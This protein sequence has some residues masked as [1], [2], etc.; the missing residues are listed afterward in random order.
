M[1]ASIRRLLRAPL[2]CGLMAVAGLPVASAS[3]G[4]QDLSSMVSVTKSERS[5]TDLKTK[6]VT[7]TAT[8]TIKNISTS[9]IGTPLQAVFDVSSAGVQAL[10][11][12]AL[13]PGNPY[14]RY[15][16]D[17]ASNVASGTLQPSNSVTFSVR[18][19]S[20]S[21]LRY[22]Y[23]II[24]YGTVIKA[25]PTITWINPAAINYGTA[26]SATQLNATA[27]VPGS[28]AYTPAA[29]TVLSV[30]GHSLK[31][32]FTPTD[33]TNYTLASATVSITVNQAVNLPPVANAGTDRTVT[34]TYGQTTIKIALDGSSSSDPDGTITA[35]SWSGAPKPD[36]S[37]APTVALGEGV[38][39]FSLVVTDNA[40]ATSAPKNVVIT[41]IREVVRPPLLLVSPPPYQVAAGSSIPLT[42][43][44]SATSPDNRLVSLAATPAF[45]NASYG[46]TSGATANGTLTF[47]PDFPQS[48]AYFITFT[49][50]D[51]YGLTSSTTIPITVAKT[52]RPPVLTLQETATI[53][54]GA[55]LTIPV[56]A[57]DPDGDILTLTATGLPRNAIFS[58][59]AGAINFNPDDNQAGTFT[60][61]VTASDGQ[62]VTSK[63]ITIA[64]IDVPG[65]GANP[66]EALT[67]MVNPVEKLNFL[68]TQRI[69]GT[70]NGAGG[71]TSSAQKAALIVGMSPATG[72]Q[73]ATLSVTLTGDS[74]SY[75]THFAAGTSSTSFG[76][77][78]TVTAL[79][80]VSPTQAIA[81][82]VIDATAPVGARSIS[83]TTGSETAPSVVAFNVM[84]GKATVT[85][86]LLDADSGLAISGSPVIL[87]GTTFS[88]TTGSDGVF[89][90]TG[91]PS[92]VQ[93]VAVNP[94]NHEL[95]IKGITL[96]TG[97][98]IDLGELRTKST[99]YD[100]AAPPTK[101][102]LSVLGRGM[103]DTTGSLKPDDAK[104]VIRDTL[105]M[106]AG[107]EVGV[108]DDYGNQLNPKARNGAGYVNITADGIRK[109]ADQMV[110]GDSI[111]LQELL[112]AFNF[113]FQWSQGTPLTLDEWLALLQQQVNAAW[114]DP[115]NPDS[116]YALVMF[117]K[118]RALLPDPPQ[119]SPFT[120]LNPVQA[121]VFAT[122][123]YTYIFTR[124]EA[125]WGSPSKFWR[126]AFD[127]RP[128][129]LLA[130]WNSA[131]MTY[132]SF[133]AGVVTF[134]TI[135]RAATACRLAV[136]LIGMFGVTSFEQSI[137]ESP[138]ITNVEIV[139]SPQK[140]EGARVHF[141]RST[142]DNGSS[143][144]LYSLWRFNP[145][146]DDRQLAAT[147][148]ATD[149]GASGVR[150]GVLED[151]NPPV[152][153][154]FYAMTVSRLFSAYKTIPLAELQNDQPY[155]TSIQ[156]GITDPVAVF[157]TTRRLT[158][159]YSNPVSTTIGDPAARTNITHLALAPDNTIFY[160]TDDRQTIHQ[161]AVTANK[162]GFPFSYVST[163]FMAP[164]AMG[165]AVDQQGNLFSENSASDSQFGGRIFKFA[166]PGG[167]REFT[168]S[169]NYFSRDLM[170]AQPTSAGPMAMA[171]DDSLFIMDQL[172]REVKQVAVNA[173]YDP[174]RRVGQPIVK[175]P[176]EAIGQAF[177]MSLDKDGN[178]YLLYLGLQA[179][180]TA[181]ITFGP[182]S[183]LDVPK[184]K[185]E[186]KAKY[187]PV[188]NDGLITE[189]G[190][191]QVQINV[192]VLDSS[193]RPV[194][195]AE[196][197]F[198]SAQGAFYNQSGVTDYQ[199]RISATL[200]T[201]FTDHSKPLTEVVVRAT[202]PSLGQTFTKS[203]PV[204]NNQQTILDRY[205][206]AI[207]KGQTMQD[208]TY[209][210]SGQGLEA[211][212]RLVPLA[213]YAVAKLFV[214]AFVSQMGPGNVNN[215]AQLIGGRSKLGESTC[216]G[217]QSK[218]LD[219]LNAI[220]ESKADA[221]LLNGFEYGPTQV[222]GAVHHNV[223]L[224]DKRAPNGFEDGLFLDP[225]VNQTPEV[226]D[227]NTV[228][229]QWMAFAPKPDTSTYLDQFPLTSPSK[230][231]LY[232]PDPKS[233]KAPPV[234][235]QPVSGV[236][237]G[238]QHPT[239][240]EII[241]PD[242][243]HIG[244][245]AAGQPHEDTS[246]AGIYSSKG[247]TR[248][249]MSDP[250]KHDVRVKMSNDGQI[251]ITT[252]FDDKQEVHY[253]L[254]L[255]KD[256]IATLPVDYQNREQKITLDDGRQ[257]DPVSSLYSAAITGFSPEKANA[258]STLDIVVTG[259]NT[260]F[261]NGVSQGIPAVG[262][263]IN[264]LVVTS[265]TRAVANVTIA[266]DAAQ[267]QYAITVM[268]GTELTTPVKTLEVD[269]P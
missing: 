66:G 211:L 269:R 57:S 74:G 225:W 110:R 131:L 1:I 63:Q 71:Q 160:L 130:S 171:P 179:P 190:T 245:D 267:G 186:A 232:Y 4:T 247:L 89:T 258:G 30:G 10:D 118:G 19:V 80:V 256:R 29:G 53:A 220:R 189:Y 73:G 96:Q 125:G 129:Y 99:V 202:V 59:A 84:K 77:G 83:V 236:V 238:P 106:I 151:P 15:Y 253:E 140:I 164:G 20:P 226:Y 101:S 79:S 33:T 8:I 194:T 98:T 82:I 3:A 95:V 261:Q 97:A 181:G 142:S 22:T 86:K 235:P 265:P 182:S 7:T 159:D 205:F 255:E 70:V 65:G 132:N 88:T 213:P 243:N 231:T 244:T 91:I 229:A 157:R 172:S 204:I 252:F 199:G 200:E 154:F 163:G 92:G 18:L 23:K 61:T 90:L 114:A 187:V 112:F 127:V 2:I 25:T 177:D 249:E 9:M 264:S 207:P 6:L 153:T 144:F 94:A 116:A 76:S 139:T 196:V 32:D 197:R 117:N 14:G 166:P 149:I 262:I 44:V 174:Y 64:V 49:A 266:G 28:F 5:V 120:M 237:I 216:G 162:L 16:V 242:G 12:I 58:P 259:V 100:P 78:I 124:T 188:R 152:G 40:G 185:F 21:T 168:G 178:I 206:V 251:Y 148:L 34:L 239:N 115:N 227:I 52:N 180:P 198:A 39:T 56:S 215:T 170:F 183:Y 47:K 123:L 137:P 135:A 257:I 51:S 37:A 173:T 24:T 38:Y 248:I 136:D 109:L 193:S 268:T 221:Y 167:A 228:R 41:V 263:T 222:V 191:S 102:I 143:S 169:L 113:G 128:N 50:R 240:I 150:Q 254:N 176:D 233:L 68:A 175:I 126:N 54:E 134:P 122:S 203:I 223:V 121:H 147:V 36:N 60:V 195:G 48:G 165:L 31:V 81:T 69:T 158:S 67:L 72:D 224:W 161:I 93:T 27:S 210:T 155:W 45:A 105:L 212:S 133:I 85:G 230:S 201:L 234:K 214:L 218:V 104:K 192:L 46:S 138:R 146:N 111:E 145:A 209:Y 17:L 43:A 107:N 62:L 246:T 119:L 241:D 26:L 35:Y 11:A 55:V 108:M 250:R 219:F 103:G 260:H 208:G 42:V 184:N 156:S 13:G 141:S 87:Q 75:P 217:Y